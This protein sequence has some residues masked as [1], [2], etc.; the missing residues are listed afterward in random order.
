[1]SV[2]AVLVVVALV[3]QEVEHQ[4]EVV[5][6]LAFLEAYPYQVALAFRVVVVLS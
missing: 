4:E 5:L 2:T 1:V 6:S 3:C